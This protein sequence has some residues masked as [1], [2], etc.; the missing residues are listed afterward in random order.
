MIYDLLKIFAPAVFSFFAGIFITPIATKYFYKYKLWKRFSR[1]ESVSTSE[2][3]KIH[4]T[5]SELNTPRVGGI[6]IWFSVIVSVLFFYIISSIF[7]YEVFKKINFLSRSQTLV[8][9]FALLLGSFVGL[10]DD[11][12]QIYGKGPIAKDDKTWR[13]WKVLIITVSSLVLGFWFYFKIDITSISIPFGGVFEL[14]VLV[15]PFFVIVALATF[16]GGVIDGIDGLAGGVFTSIFAAYALIAFTNNQ[17]DIAAFSG[18]LSGAILAFLWFNIPPARFYMGETGVMGLAIVLAVIA[19]L[20]DTVLILPVIA[21]PLVM[22]S[23]SVILQLLSKKFLGKKVFKVAPL[24]HHF[25]SL[26]W[27]REKITMRYWVISIIFAIFG[28]ILKVIS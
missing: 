7:D 26:G 15:I 14:G 8:P 18:V 19:F 11:L 4:N 2:F 10:W 27:S 21:F 12:V 20:T 23:F 3:K 13:L 1:S 5:S 9:F 25:E 24:H 6:I 17:M 16:S 22:S 28:V